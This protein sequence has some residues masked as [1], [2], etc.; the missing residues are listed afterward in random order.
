MSKMIKVKKSKLSGEK[1]ETTSQVFKVYKKNT[2]WTFSKC[3]DRLLFS[4]PQPQF[5]LNIFVFWIQT[6]TIE[7]EVSYEIYFRCMNY[8]IW[9]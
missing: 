8:E 7:P 9:L 4:F 6:T 3:L 1:T 2:I 5:L